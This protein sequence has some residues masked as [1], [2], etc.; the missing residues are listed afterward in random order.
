MR[1]DAVVNRGA[2]LR[3]RAE[4]LTEEDVAAMV[5]VDVRT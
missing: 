1:M 2:V 3:E 4:L 5:D